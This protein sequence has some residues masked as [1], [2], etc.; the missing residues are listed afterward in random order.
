M[1]LRNAILKV[2]VLLGTSITRYL[3]EELEKMGIDLSNEGESYFL[4]EIR[5]GLDLIFGVEAAELLMEQIKK[6]LGNR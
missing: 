6:E 3:I 4:H 5:E 1:A 2:E